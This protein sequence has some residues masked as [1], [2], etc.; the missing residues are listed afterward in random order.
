MS[1]ASRCRLGG[2]GL[3][4]ICIL[5]FASL[6]LP[7][8]GC[9]GAS[10]QAQQLGGLGSH[11]RVLSIPWRPR[12]LPPAAQKGGGWLQAAQHEHQEHSDP[13]V[14]SPLC[15]S[16]GCS[17]WSLS[18]WASW[19]TCPT[20]P[21]RQVALQPWQMPLLRS[22]T[23]RPWHFAAKCIAACNVGTLALRLPA[24]IQQHDLLG[25]CP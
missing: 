5:V 9:W 25:Q 22:S 14:L 7:C 15:L 3:P 8:A 4:W 10:M 18:T 19:W 6:I 21:C 12:A 24:S 23:G 17:M 20:H 1:T 2:L 16:P 11:G 13:P